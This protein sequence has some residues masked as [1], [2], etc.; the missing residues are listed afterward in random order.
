[1][2]LPRKRE[3]EKKQE[4]RGNDMGLPRRTEERKRT[5][6]EMRKQKGIKRASK[7][8]RKNKGKKLSVFWL[9]FFITSHFLY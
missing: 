7:K 1:M 9:L 2:E 6:K 5:Q 3:R 8:K 4:K